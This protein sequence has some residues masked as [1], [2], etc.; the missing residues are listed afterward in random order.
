MSKEAVCI[1]AL[2]DRILAQND[3][4]KYQ[5]LI[6][7]ADAKDVNNIFRFLPNFLGGRVVKDVSIYPP[8]IILT[9]DSV[10]HIRLIDSVRDAYY[11]AGMEVQYIEEIGELTPKSRLYISTLK[12]IRVPQ[13]EVSDMEILSTHIDDS[14]LKRLP[15]LE[16]YEHCADASLYS[17]ELGRRLEGI[18]ELHFNKDSDL[19]STDR[20]AI[21]ARYLEGEES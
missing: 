20:Q 16:V 5:M 2:A 14:T 18:R 9:D 6:A 3:F 12:R 4:K 10:I 19:Y 11:L 7:C 17:K 15:L 21:M 13:E 1:K 8:R